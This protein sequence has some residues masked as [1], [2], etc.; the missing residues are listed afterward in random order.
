M[1]HRPVIVLQG[2]KGLEANPVVRGDEE[3]SQNSD[4]RKGARRQGTV[5][6]AEASRF[7]KAML[8]GVDSGMRTIAST[9]TVGTRKETYDKW[10]AEAEYV[11]TASDWLCLLK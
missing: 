9:Q 11:A 5:G 7:G 8:A 3:S 6:L 10:R 4:G 2:G 1:Y